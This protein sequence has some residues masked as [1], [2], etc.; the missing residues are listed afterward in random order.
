MASRISNKWFIRSLDRRVVVKWL[1][2]VPAI[3]VSLLGRAEEA[4]AS[5]VRGFFFVD[6]PCFGRVALLT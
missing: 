3:T 2:M 6:Y 4:L 1:V 5:T